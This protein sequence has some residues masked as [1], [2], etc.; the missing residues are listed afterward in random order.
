MPGKS[1]FFDSVSGMLVA[2][3]FV[4]SAKIVNFVAHLVK[5]ASVKTTIHHLI[6]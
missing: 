6:L 5:K 2:G 3:C 1:I 4:M